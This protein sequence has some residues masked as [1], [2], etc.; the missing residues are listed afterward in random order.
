MLA[1]NNLKSFPNASFKKTVTL[2]MVAGVVVREVVW[3][4]IVKLVVVVNVV[5]VMVVVILIVR[6]VGAQNRCLKSLRLLEKIFA[7]IFLK[8]Y[9]V[10]KMCLFELCHLKEHWTF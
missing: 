6:F 1:G 7:M 5:V 10:K 4:V 3:D 9:Q 2:V 8:N